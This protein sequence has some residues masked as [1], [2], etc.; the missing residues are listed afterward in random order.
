MAPHPLDPL[1]AA[2]IS[3]ASALLRAFAQLGPE[4][5]FVSVELQEPPKAALVARESER[6]VADALAPPDR[7]AFCVLY[8]RGTRRT[9]EAVVSLTAGTVV[10][11]RVVPGVQPSIMM[12]EVL[13]C[14]DA[15]RAD[16]AWQAAMASR[17][18]TDL[19]LAMIDIWSAGYTGSDDDPARRRIAR[20]LTFVR[21]APGENGYARPVEGLTVVVDL[22]AMAVVEVVDHA[23]AGD[24]AT[25]TDGPAGDA[26]TGHA[27]TGHGTT[28]HGIVPLPPRP[29]NYIPGL[30]TADPDNVPA[31]D[32]LRDDLRPIEV[33][34][35]QG[36]SFT[37][38]GHALRW[39][40]WELRVG[41]TP[42]EGLVL[43]QIAYVD[44]GRRRP[45]IQRASVSEMFVPYGDPA[46]T[47]RV[48]NVFDMGE[49]GVG[50]L[51]NSLRL[52]CDCLGE[53]TYL[54]AVV[55][56]SAGE[57]V[58]IPNAVC[59]HEEDTGIAWKHTD[60]RT[61]HVEVRRMRRLVISMISTVGNYEYGFFWYLHLDGS[62]EFE[63]KLTG[64]ISS[65]AV[66][67]GASPTHGVLVA[68]G[69]YGPNHQH[70]FNVRLDME[71]DG[72][73]NSVVEV[74]SEPEPPGPGNPTGV[75]WRTKET[76]LLTE[77]E[78]QRVVDPA[79]ARFWRITN[80]RR[81]GP[82]GRPVAYR[83]VPGHTAPLLAHPASHQ[84]ARGRFAARNLWVTAFDESER[85]AAGAYP[86]QSAGGAGLPRYAAADRP[87]ADT[88]I[89]VWYS[90]G[91]HHV[92]RPEDWPVMPVSRIGFELRPDGFFDG[93]PAL[94]LPPTAHDGAR[95]GTD[96]GTSHTTGGGA[97]REA[98]RPAAGT[99]RSHLG[100][101]TAEG[102]CGC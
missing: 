53:I 79:A 52:G 18:V 96:H 82:L 47:H 32:R 74:D 63:V 4:F 27:T 101:G 5:R 15:V 56:D 78:A 38:D 51:A 98:H 31:F 35:P 55:N 30:M 20:P 66:R 65:G 48:K 26:T 99:G 21:A 42:R 59:I 11:L 49:Y 1:S 80:P 46:P 13:A 102:A 61:D 12:D 54:D 60:F 22:D 24:D 91:A 34:Q 97:D 41:F 25:G 89:V 67:P 10:D 73:P 92:V 93:N 37:L 83:L 19:S 70:F 57:P 86:N 16:G 62:L 28:G 14:E 9:H 2:E 3:R 39:Q 75:A 81:H 40:R 23:A 50:R 58:T 87:V 45:L 88:D 6:E 90:F 100:G 33:S 84:A 8:E 17:G 36:A 94:D 72:G 85:F 69:L 64:V 43:H 95:R 71:L 29:G 76:P 68:P 77:S 7:Q 44:R